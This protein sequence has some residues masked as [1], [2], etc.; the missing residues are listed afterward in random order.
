VVI[1]KSTVVTKTLVNENDLLV[2]KIL[3]I[4]N[5]SD[6]IFGNE[7]ISNDK[8]RWQLKN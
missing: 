7:K 1:K 2:T 8:K 6:Q 3:A 4:E 5:V